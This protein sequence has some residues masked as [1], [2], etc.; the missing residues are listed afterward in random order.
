MD[1]QDAQDLDSGVRRSVVLGIRKPGADHRPSRLLVQQ[2]HVLLILC[3]HVQKNSVYLG[4]RLVYFCSEAKMN[5]SNSG[6]SGAG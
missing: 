6:V 3:I 5:E 2:P 1:A 4:V